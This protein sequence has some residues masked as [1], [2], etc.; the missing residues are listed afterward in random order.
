MP[1]NNPDNSVEGQETSALQE[2]TAYI[3]V[4]TLG[5]HVLGG[6]RQEL[7]QETISSMLQ[8]ARTP[9]EKAT[10]HVGH[11]ALTGP[12]VLVLR[13]FD[14]FVYYQDNKN[15]KN[16]LR[17][18]LTF[19]ATDIIVDRL[20]KNATWATPFYNVLLISTF[21]DIVDR[22]YLEQATSN[23]LKLLR[24]WQNEALQSDSYFQLWA[25]QELEADIFAGQAVFKLIALPSKFLAYAQKWIYSTLFPEQPSSPKNIFLNSA[26]VWPNN[27]L[28]KDHLKNTL[29]TSDSLLD[30]IQKKQFPQQYL[31]QQQLHLSCLKIFAPLD[32]LASPPLQPSSN[33]SGNTLSTIEAIATPAEKISPPSF[34]S[35][36]TW[37]PLP[38]QNQTLPQAEKLFANHFAKQ[39]Q[40][41]LAEAPYKFKDIPPFQPPENNQS[42]MPHSTSGRISF[43]NE[44]GK[45]Q[46]YGEIATS[47][48][49]VVAGILAG[50]VLYDQIRWH[51]L[52]QD[53]Q[54]DYYIRNGLNQYLDAET[55]QLGW[56]DWAFSSKE[57]VLKNTKKSNLD[58][59]LKAMRSTTDPEKKGLL[60]L[61]YYAQ[62]SDNVPILQAIRHQ[63][64]EKIKNAYQGMCSNRAAY[65]TWIPY[66]LSEKNISR[67]HS[68]LKDYK[69]KFPLEPYTPLFQAQVALIQGNIVQV[70]KLLDDTR[71]KLSHATN[72]NS[73]ARYQQQLS[74]SYVEFQLN[75]AKLKHV[76][77]LKE[78]GELIEQCKNII[79]NAPTLAKKN[80]EVQLQIEDLTP[81]S[82]RRPTIYLLGN[83]DPKDIQKLFPATIGLGHRLDDTNKDHTLITLLSFIDE[84][85]HN[86]S[87]ADK[88][89]LT[90]LL[91]NILQISSY[92][93]QIADY[94]I[95]HH[96]ELENYQAAIEIQ[97]KLCETT[98]TPDTY[99]NLGLLY[100]QNGEE[101]IAIQAAVAFNTYLKKIKNS[102]EITSE[103]AQQAYVVLL[104][105]AIE[106]DQWDNSISLAKQHEH[107][108]PFLINAL[109]AKNKFTEAIAC[110][111]KFCEAQ[112]IADNFLKLGELYYAA[113]L[114]KITE[115]SVVSFVA[116]EALD[117]FNTYIEKT[118][119]NQNDTTDK[120]LLFAHR[121]LSRE[122]LQQKNL[123]KANLHADKLTKN[124]FCT[125]YDFLLDG[126][127]KAESGLSFSSIQSLHNALSAS[128]DENTTQNASQLLTEHKNLAKQLLLKT[129]RSLFSHTIAAL[130]EVTKN[131]KNPTV[132][133]IHLTFKLISF[134]N[135]TALPLGKQLSQYLP[136]HSGNTDLANINQG[137]YFEH[138]KLGHQL[139]SLGCEAANKIIN[140]YEK[141]TNQECH[142]SIKNSVYYT[143]QFAQL[144]SYPITGYQLYNNYLQQ[145]E[146]LSKIPQL[147][148]GYSFE[149]KLAK[150]SSSL[151]LTELVFFGTHA[152]INLTD[153]IV[154]NYSGQHIESFPFHFAKVAAAKG[155]QT[156]VLLNL[157]SDAGRAAMLLMT[158]HQYISAAQI[159]AAWNAL[160]TTTYYVWDN[161]KNLDPLAATLVLG[162]VIVVGFVGYKFVQWIYD[163]AGLSQNQAILQ[164][165]QTCH[166]EKN[167]AEVLNK[168]KFLDNNG[169]FNHAK[170]LPQEKSYAL[171]L[172]A[173]A[174]KQTGNEDESKN[175]LLKIANETTYPIQDRYTAHLNLINTAIEK[176][177]FDAA[178]S[179]AENIEK[180]LPA[181]EKNPGDLKIDEEN[182]RI[183]NLLDTLHIQK[184]I[185]LYN[186]KK[187][188]SA[189]D[190]L[191]LVQQ[192]GEFFQEQRF[193]T[194]LAIVLEDK[195]YKKA[196]TLCE[197]QFSLRHTDEDTVST[198]IQL[199]QHFVT[200]TIKSESIDEAIPHLEKI[201]TYG[202]K[203]LSL[204]ENNMNLSLTN[205]STKQQETIKLLDTAY[206]TQA[207]ILANKR[208][209]VSA[210][211]NYHAIQNKAPEVQDKIFSTELTLD[212]KDKQYACAEKKCRERLSK[213]T[214]DKL[215]LHYLAIIC[216]QQGNETA[217]TDALNQLL[218]HHADDLSLYTTVQHQLAF[219]EFNKGYTGHAKQRCL[220]IEKFLQL[221]NESFV[222]CLEKCKQ[223]KTPDKKS[224]DKITHEIK[225]CEKLAQDNNKLLKEFETT[226]GQIWQEGLSQMAAS[227]I[228]P[229]LKLMLYDSKATRATPEILPNAHF[230]FEQKI[231][232]DKKETNT[233]IAVKNSNKIP[234][235]IIYQ[236]SP[237]L[238]NKKSKTKEKIHLDISHTPK[239]S[240]H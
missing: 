92:N 200:E 104:Q 129:A 138:I 213:K 117:A 21:A 88:Q 64:N 197:E 196:L 4:P 239:F 19:T 193:R 159:E 102:S 101:K 115:D 155:Y 52:S 224:S 112:P 75:L 73:A 50:K 119:E 176:K 122:Y 219:I 201:I 55:D 134:I 214:H 32:M 192:P 95:Q 71:H 148:T 72:V 29:S 114:K 238:F 217:A 171:Q 189:L 186:E 142:S 78:R 83:E 57:E 175:V 121:V 70:E 131:N 96:C 161:A 226:I 135:D 165:A 143:T 97:N 218:T 132:E 202:H 17:K 110:Q 39:R 49:A 140:H 16:P 162:G 139:I 12:K 68:L 207:D 24:S 87:S 35:I 46:W 59:L 230:L 99:R 118:Q 173:D 168:I 76:T 44:T 123:A 94:L 150:L 160:T 133:K 191:N 220:D 169:F 27:F 63:D 66:H 229:V 233:S 234:I 77:S 237:T 205:L 30:F 5:E 53:A 153:I 184:S 1:T 223:E 34:V 13:G 227:L 85:K 15:E 146:A 206:E 137:K 22:H 188:T 67:V 40:Q 180:M 90:P 174:L 51:L 156:V 45:F 98:Q 187:F 128:S 120:H 74:L 9:F 36:P 231:S 41:M 42:F 212:I 69:Q 172:K 28:G 124:H 179:L 215:S 43:S 8:E 105:H 106:Q 18:A 54:L 61:M 185:H 167:Y 23:N 145:K 235:K 195:E 65:L 182:K 84:A 20:L 47:N 26:S 203:K 154:K 62:I 178:F 151:A 31:A 181:L 86:S 216:L 48:P 38:T 80:N 157:A 11:V 79:K 166:K 194:Q 222:E 81:F 190:E 6:K 149:K 3:V 127:I 130:S 7:I 91:E 136:T 89:Q 109:L 37:Q 221:K 126:I 113:H 204:L 211:K 116:Q 107:F 199:H 58:Y 163:D 170:H 2:I 14:T 93:Q 228:D 144:A 177:E 209:F 125:A 100:L 103:K 158:A 82:N 236:S 183:R 152:A 164:N 141:T 198:L 111:K 240:Y 147:D 232:Y 108:R 208:D 56:W 25:A 60:D 210:L 225:C 33:D 10:V